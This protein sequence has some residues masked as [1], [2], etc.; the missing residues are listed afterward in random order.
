MV[1]WVVRKG[2]GSNFLANEY[3]IDVKVYRLY[4]S[5]VGVVVEGPFVAI[6]S[7]NPLMLN[8]AIADLPSTAPNPRVSW[9]PNPIAGLIAASLSR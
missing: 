9:I 1:E 2:W 7:N 6:L 5:R 3:A 8:E 4:G